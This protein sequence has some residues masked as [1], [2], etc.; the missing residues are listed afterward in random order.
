MTCPRC[1][2][3][4]V[5]VQM[6][7]EQTLKRK[8]HGIAWWIFIGWWYAPLKWLWNFILFAVKWFVFTVPALILTIFRIKPTKQKP[9]YILKNKH[10]SMYVCQDCGHHW[11]AK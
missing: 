7:S 4:N 10:Y 6:V 9:D 8:R 1:H 3:E 2:S 5:N 11:K